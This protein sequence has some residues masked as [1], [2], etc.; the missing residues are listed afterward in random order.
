[1]TWGAGWS[2]GRAGLA[3]VERKRR[4]A[5]R[6]VCRAER[7]ESWIV[8]REKEFWAVAC[9][10]WASLLRARAP[11]GGVVGR[12]RKAGRFVCRAERVRR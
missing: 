7:V 11:A 10:G 3:R 8:I 1:V 2:L 5:G 4:K 6:F 9:L 12:R